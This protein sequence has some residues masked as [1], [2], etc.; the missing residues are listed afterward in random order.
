M[1]TNQEGVTNMAD[2]NT[3]I[4]QPRD[5]GN[6]DW[7]QSGYIGTTND[8]GGKIIPPQGGSGTIDP[9]GG[10]SNPPPQGDKSE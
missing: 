4:P 5:I 8:G 2:E 1:N 10:P 9:Q 7:A 6:P 3:T